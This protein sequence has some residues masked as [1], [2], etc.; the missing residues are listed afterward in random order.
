MVIPFRHTDMSEVSI[1]Y[2]GIQ[3]LSMQEFA[4]SLDFFDILARIVLFFAVCD[5]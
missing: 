5:Q 4:L 3:E 1:L 2:N